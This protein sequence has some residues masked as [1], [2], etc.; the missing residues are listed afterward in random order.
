M[1]KRVIAKGA[2]GDSRAK[3]NRGGSGRGNIKR[4]PCGCPSRQHYKTC[5]LSRSYS[6]R[7]GNRNHAGD[8]VIDEMF[9][10]T[11]LRNTASK[12]QK[13]LAQA[14]LQRRKKLARATAAR[15]RAAR[16]KKKKGWD[17]ALVS[18]LPPGIIHGKYASCVRCKGRGPLHVMARLNPKNHRQAVCGGCD[19]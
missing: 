5:V 17:W 1:S 15:K 11:E 14:A 2:K 18:I 16:R 13:T 7:E 9:G 12:A 6:D 4:R 8:A 3:G 19:S 10:V